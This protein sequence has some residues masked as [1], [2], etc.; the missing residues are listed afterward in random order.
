MDDLEHELARLLAESV[1]D[2]RP[3]V[4]VMVAE[5]NRR[6]RRLLLRRR[7]KIAGAVAA[8]GTLALAGT[9]LG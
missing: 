4:A 5:A 9:V 7:L 2:L 3:P 8:V 6:G 1:E